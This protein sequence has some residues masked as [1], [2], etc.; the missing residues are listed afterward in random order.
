M[1]QV[2]ACR[3]APCVHYFVLAATTSRWDRATPFLI[4]IILLIITVVTTKAVIE[5]AEARITRDWTP[6]MLKLLERDSKKSPKTALLSLTWLA[7]AAQIPVLL[8]TP[9]VGLFILEH[10]VNVVLYT[11]VMAAG[12]VVFL[13]AYLM[14]EI[15]DYDRLRLEY[16]GLRLSII[17]GGGILVNLACAVIAYVK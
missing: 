15:T 8:G 5:K 11:A 9:L 1:G 3:H 7:D 10:H 4:G 13:I 16:R 12:I 17:T 6:E 14:Q 2:V